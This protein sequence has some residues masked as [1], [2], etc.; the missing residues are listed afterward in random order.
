MTTDVLYSELTRIVELIGEVCDRTDRRLA[1]IRN[2][3]ALL[4]TRVDALTDGINRPQR[5]A[6]KPAPTGRKGK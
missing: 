4:A 3:L 1:A 2:R 6:S 5:R